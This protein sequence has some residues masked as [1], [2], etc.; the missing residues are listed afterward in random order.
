MDHCGLVLIVK[1]RYRTRNCSCSGIVVVF[2]KVTISGLLTI[3]VAL[4]AAVSWHFGAPVLLNLLSADLSIL[5]RNQHGARC[6]RQNR[7]GVANPGIS[8]K[9]GTDHDF[10]G[11]FADLC[12]PEHL[13][14]PFPQSTVF[15]ANR[16]EP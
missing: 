7:R 6:S 14:K 11:K 9:T 8:P 5:P 4:I 1:S 3:H 16:R 12:G 15:S 2:E 10:L 13:A